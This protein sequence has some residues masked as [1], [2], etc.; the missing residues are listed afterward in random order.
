VTPTEVS[1]LDQKY[2]VPAL[3]NSPLGKAL[4]KEKLQPHTI[5]LPGLPN[6][7]HLT[8][9]TP[10]KDGLHLAFDLGPNIVTPACNH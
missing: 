6:G 8:S 7:I 10:A 3:L 9:A 4:P 1:A 5:P 2:S